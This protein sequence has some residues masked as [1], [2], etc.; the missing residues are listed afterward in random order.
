MTAAPALPQPGVVAPEANPPE[1]PDN[2]EPQAQDWTALY[3]N[4]F[5]RLPIQIVTAL[6]AHI[7]DFQQRDKFLRR[8]EVLHDRKMRFYDRGYQHIYAT[9]EGSYTQGTAGGTVPSASGGRDIQLPNYIDDYNIF[10]GY[11]RI[12]DSV[13]TQNPPGINFRPIDGSSSYDVEAAATAEDYPKLFN[14]TNDAKQIQAQIVRMFRL[15]GRTIIWTRTEA[16]SQLYGYTQTGTPKQMEVAT[17]HGTLESKVSIMA[18]CPQDLGICG[19]FKDIDLNIA[20][21]TYPDLPAE[22]D[23]PEVKRAAEFKGGKSGLGESEYERTARLGVLQGTRSLGQQGDSFTH[24][25][26]LQNYFLRPSEFASDHF[27]NTVEELTGSEVGGQVPTIAERLREM[28]PDGFQIVF[29]GDTYCGGQPQ[30]F[31]DALTIGFPYVGEGMYRQAIMDPM[32]TVQD[33]FSDNMNGIAENFDT[34]WANLWINAADQDYEAIVGQIASPNAIRQMKNVKAGSKVS[35]MLH[36]EENAD[37]PPTLWQFVELLQG[38]LPAFMLATPP[39]LQGAA[40]EDQKTASGYAQARNQAMGQQAIFFAVIQAMMANMYRQAALCAARN[41]DHPAQVV[42]PGSNGSSTTLQLE[43]LSKGKFGAYPDADSSFPETIQQKRETLKLIFEMVLQSPELAMQ[44]L[45]SPDNWKLFS[46]VMGFSELKIPEGDVR[47]KAQF[48]IE[49]L[50]DSAPVPDTQGLEQMQVQHAAA[51]VAA[52]MQNQPEPMAPT[53]QYQSSVP[54]SPFAFVEWEF[55]YFKEWLSSSKAR[56]VMA[57][58]TTDPKKILGMKNVLL[59]TAE[60]QA[61]LPPPPMMP[62]PSPKLGDPPPSS[63]APPA[64]PMAP[65]AATM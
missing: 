21:S 50:L 29:V 58:G 18:T 4:K 47:D 53:L 27:E 19:L 3:G 31:D 61:A 49:Q 15:S 37:L 20:K 25:I 52:R 59:H 11:G 8:R 57:E 41:P 40:M 5:E 35:D 42:I 10:T 63:G 12:I 14:R 17:V 48:E 2:S 46:E 13:L 44:I 33:R 36:R 1:L 16:N 24:L 23:L 7:Q 43:R 51:S 60:L 30:S 6:K 56:Q 45:S 26:T 32:V 62:V 64:K 39:A 28:F 54:V 38:P 22:G 34:G 9:R 65:P 55:A